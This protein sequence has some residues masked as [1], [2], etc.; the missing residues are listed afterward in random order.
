[1]V[2]LMENP[3]H[4]S[5]RVVSRSMNQVYLAA[6][7]DQVVSISHQGRRSFSL[8]SL[9]SLLETIRN[10][11]Q[12]LE[13]REDETDLVA[14]LNARIHHEKDQIRM[15]ARQIAVRYGHSLAI[16]LLTL[17][18][19]KAENRAARRDWSE[20]H[21]QYWADI[22]TV[23]LGGGLAAG[24]MGDIVTHAAQS[25]VH[26]LGYSDYRIQLAPQGANLALVGTQKL[27]N[28]HEKSSLLFDF[29]HTTVKRGICV[30]GEMVTLP[31][32]SAHCPGGKYREGTPAEAEEQL[33]Y[34]L[35]L[36][37][38]TWN[39]AKREGYSLSNEMAV[40][41]ACY[42]FEGHP[43]PQD[44]GCYGQLQ[45]LTSHLQTFLAEQLSQTLNKKINLHLIHDGTAA[46]LVYDGSPNTAVL[47]LGTAVGIG[48]PT[49]N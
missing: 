43:A 21:W 42:L 6:L 18:Q 25:L 37:E 2:K 20:A 45:L 7:P 48:F 10:Y 23:W 1:M 47:T 27:L 16:V 40:S 15:V 36:I 26:E 8:L 33:S 24:N 49:A 44:L 41:L 30:H 13:I 28:N 46:A 14:A 31:R 39:E 12:P 22:D 9:N 5:S 32:M 29:G 4:T 34:M 35:Q 3:F 11:A 17:K 19:G 38:Q